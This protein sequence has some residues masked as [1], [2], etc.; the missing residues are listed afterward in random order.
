MWIE[1]S[2]GSHKTRSP[3]AKLPF[4]IDHRRYTP[5]SSCSSDHRLVANV[6]DGDCGFWSLAQ[7]SFGGLFRSG[8]SSGP[9]R[10][11]AAIAP[12]SGL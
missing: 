4:A 3:I 12:G 11:V 10:T 1:A 2:G 5:D 7:S 8:E 6:P 9:D